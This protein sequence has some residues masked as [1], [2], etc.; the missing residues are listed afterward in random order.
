MH[1]I[2]V[3]MLLVIG[4]MARGAVVYTSGHGDIGVSYVGGSLRQHY[5]FDEDA[6]VGGL[7]PAVEAF[8]PDALITFVAGP[9]VARPAGA[10]WN[11][12]GAASGGALWFLPQAEDPQKPFLGI[13]SEDLTAS[14]WTSLTFSLTAINAP[15]G[16][17]FS[18]YQTDGFGQPIVHLASAD[19]ITAADSHALTVGG[20]A[21]YNW[22]FTQPGMYA[23]EFTFTGTHLTDGPKSASSTFTFGVTQVPEPGS[24]AFVA[25]AT[26]ALLRRRRWR[27]TLNHL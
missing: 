23:L 27:R 9:P 4:P 26:T 16:G 18:L 11:F 2:I 22:V 7:V 14:Q 6:V 20:H 1:H 15:A 19:G 13:A 10:Q 24:A 25:L 17:S 21:H 3:L 5:H 8:E 12:M